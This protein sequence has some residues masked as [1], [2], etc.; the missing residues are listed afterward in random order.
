MKLIYKIENLNQLL[1]EKLISIFE[2]V[3]NY[4]MIENLTKDLSRKKEIFKLIVGNLTIYL[5]NNKDY[6]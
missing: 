3:V 4:L 6:K 1:I 5:N 2:I